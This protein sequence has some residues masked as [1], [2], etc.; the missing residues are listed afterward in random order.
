MLLKCRYHTVTRK[1]SFLATQLAPELQRQFQ[2]LP[3][4]K[5]LQFDDMETME[6]TKCKPLSITL[7]VDGETRRILGC[8]VS[9][10]AAKG[11][12]AKIALKKYGPR[13]S[14]RKKARE[15]LLKQLQPWVARNALIQ[16]DQDPRYPSS[17]RKF[18]PEA[19]HRAYKGRRGCVVGQG[20]LKRGG[21][22]PLFTLNQTAAMLRANMNRLFRRSW[23]TTKKP[24][25]LMEHLILYSYFHNQFIIPKGAK[26]N[27]LL[28]TA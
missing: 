9:P 1:V 13:Q 19:E 15:H 28:S 21:F 12:L 26:A 11:K 27:A 7:A 22:D 3:E 16:T 2:F 23:N 8:S 5:N 6:H 20:E 4:I 17:I 25:R 24:E 14:M 10:I 18:F